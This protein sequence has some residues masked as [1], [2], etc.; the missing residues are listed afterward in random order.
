MANN[1]PQL[2]DLHHLS[3]SVII[4]SNMSCSNTAWTT[5][6]SF[7]SRDKNV[8]CKRRAIT[9]Q[10]GS[11]IKEVN[12]WWEKRSNISLCNQAS[13]LEDFAPSNLNWMSD[14]CEDRISGFHWLNWASIQIVL[15]NFRSSNWHSRITFVLT[16]VY[17]SV[18]LCT[19]SI[20]NTILTAVY[21]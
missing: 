6:T 21:W 20:E 19:K 2:P 9:K 16:D 5:N 4:S 11:R 14:K 15:C 17:S 7:G 18:V 3:G 13:Y 12:C 8:T 1:T 10:T